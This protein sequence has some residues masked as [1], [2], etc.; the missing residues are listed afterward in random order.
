MPSLLP[1]SFLNVLPALDHFPLCNFNFS[2]TDLLALTLFPTLIAHFQH[3]ICVRSF[4]PVSSHFLWHL[5]KG[6]YFRSVHLNLN[7]CCFLWNQRQQ[8]WF[9][10]FPMAL[11]ALCW[12]SKFLILPKSMQAEASCST[13]LPVFHVESL[14]WQAKID[15]LNSVAIVLYR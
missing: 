3:L 10:G 5:L 2:L 1:F 9:E 7:S 15:P 12:K 13:E 4:N 14:C 11:L 6:L 8:Q